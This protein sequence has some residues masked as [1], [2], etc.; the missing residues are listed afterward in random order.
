MVGGE[1]H[2][3][4]IHLGRWKKRLRRHIKEKIYLAVILH[5]NAQAA[6][7]L[8]AGFRRHALNHFPLEHKVHISNQ[9]LIGQQMEYQRCRDV[10]GQVANDAQWAAC[11]ESG[12]IEFQGVLLDQIEIIVVGKFARQ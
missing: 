11:I 3:G 4:G 2:N 9:R 7:Y 10:V 5:N 6:V 8:G 12:E 1:P